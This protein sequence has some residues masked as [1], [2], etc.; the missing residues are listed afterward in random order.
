VQ[1]KFVATLKGQG[2][3]NQRRGIMV[4][5]LVRGS[6]TAPKFR[7]DLKGLLKQGLEGNLPEPSALKK[8]LPG[9]TEGKEETKGLQEKVKGL[10]KGLPLGQ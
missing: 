1:P 5:V 8:L 6:F 4:P 9:Q 7:P 3:T 2:D 10:L